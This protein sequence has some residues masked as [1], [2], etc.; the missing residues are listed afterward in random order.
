MSVAIAMIMGIRVRVPIGVVMAVMVIMRIV[1][2]MAMAAVMAMI[3]IRT[4]AAPLG[5]PALPDQP[6]AHADHQQAGDDPQDRHQHVGHDKP[7][8]KQRP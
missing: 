8:G 2:I 7:A 3:I 1:M 5:L 4:L 6:A